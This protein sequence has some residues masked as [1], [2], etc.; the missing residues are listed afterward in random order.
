[1]QGTPL[2]EIDTFTRELTQ[3]I[4]EMQQALVTE[5]K[6]LEGTLIAEREDIVI[7]RITEDEWKEKLKAPQFQNELTKEETKTS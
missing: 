3:L 1:M 7:E 6:L 2:D 5:T 4:G